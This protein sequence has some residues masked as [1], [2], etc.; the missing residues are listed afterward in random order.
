[1]C[2]LMLFYLQ[3][4]HELMHAMSETLDEETSRF[5]TVLSLFDVKG[6]QVRKQILEEVTI[7]LSKSGNRI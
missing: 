6:L 7:I 5:P 3:D 2:S 1:M 4:C